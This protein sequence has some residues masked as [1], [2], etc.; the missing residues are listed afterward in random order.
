MGKEYTNFFSR[1][2]LSQVLYKLEKENY[3][4]CKFGQP[5]DSLLKL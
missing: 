3:M 5:E 1:N 2:N 4:E